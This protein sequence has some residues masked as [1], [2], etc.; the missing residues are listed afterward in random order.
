MS[1][2]LSVR[3]A[4][5]L[6]HPITVASTCE[7]PPPPPPEECECECD[8]PLEFTIPPGESATFYFRACCLDLP[9][10]DTV[11]NDAQ[12]TCGRWD[13]HPLIGNCM[14]FQDDREW[15]W[16][17][18]EYETTCYLVVTFIFSDDRQCEINLIAT[19]E[20]EEEP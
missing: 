9:E 8:S 20:E 3:R 16:G 19:V 11:T 7:P 15:T 4:T 5:M 1:S 10:G 17:S 18:P 6:P 12:A 2:K 14:G 13:D